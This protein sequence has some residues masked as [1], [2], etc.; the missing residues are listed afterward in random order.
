ME[1]KQIEE[2]RDLLYGFWKS[3]IVIGDKYKIIAEALYN[4]GYRKIP[5][6]SV[7]LTT[8]EYETEKQ[9]AK[10]WKERAQMWKQC[11]YDIRKETAEKFVSLLE[12]RCK[13]IVGYEYSF[14]NIR[15]VIDEICNEFT[16]ELK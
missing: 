2:L 6:I 5:E 12:E 1:E 10:Y 4:A 16:G 9:M 14:G 15:R 7:V 3:N 11:T 13:G 8:E